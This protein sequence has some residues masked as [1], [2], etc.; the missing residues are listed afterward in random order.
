MQDFILVGAV[1]PDIFCGAKVTNLR[2]EGCKLRD[3]DEG[4]EALLLDDLVGDGELVVCALLGKDGSPG[5]KAIDAL[6][7]EGLWAEILEEKIELG[8]TIGDCRAAEE[9]CS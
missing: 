2:I 4:A 5:I 1:Y 6:F 7:L 9:G 3:L 8:Q